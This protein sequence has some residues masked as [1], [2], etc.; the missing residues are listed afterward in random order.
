MRVTD[1]VEMRLFYCIQMD[2]IY[3]RPSIVQ[4]KPYII[5]NE[6]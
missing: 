6:V 4:G 5:A 3:T 2:E 1:I